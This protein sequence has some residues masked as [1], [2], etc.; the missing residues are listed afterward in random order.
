MS[1]LLYLIWSNTTILIQSSKFAD[2][3]GNTAKWLSHITSLIP[4][5]NN[6][7][8]PP[9]AAKEKIQSKLSIEGRESS[10]SLPRKR[11]EPI[12]SPGIEPYK[13]IELK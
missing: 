6:K 9:N 7:A 2:P 11:T 5:P 3:I 12:T 4:F 13:V 1:F 8:S 10:L